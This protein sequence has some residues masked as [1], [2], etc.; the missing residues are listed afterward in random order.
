MMFTLLGG[1]LRLEGPPPAE[2]ALWLAA[3]VEVT[4]HMK[5]LDAAAGG[6]VAGLAV[7]ARCPGAQVTGVEIQAGLADLANANARLNGF[8]NY[9]CVA[10]DILAFEPP[11]KVG[12]VICNPPFYPAARGHHSKDEA[13]QLARHQPEGLLA[14]WLAQL[15]TLTD[16][17]LYL[18]LH[19][20]NQTELRTLGDRLRLA[21]EIVPLAT[22][23]SR[24]PKRLL[25]RIRQAP[26][27]AWL[28]GAP[29]NA[30]GAPERVAVLE[31]GGAVTGCWPRR[32]AD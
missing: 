10:G 26:K 21:I 3:S 6:G 9:T 17:P 16:G 1:R 28:E 4:P 31:R 2:D 15:L 18:V 24:P 19:S 25:A 32:R 8:E 20:T 29:L 14:K 27:T 5:I 13:R 12:A 7:L 30:Y 11:E 23:A 22:H